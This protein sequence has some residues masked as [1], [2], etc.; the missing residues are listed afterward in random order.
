MIE[1]HIVILSFQKSDN[2]LSLGLLAGIYK[3]KNKP[4][5]KH[6]NLVIMTCVFGE[7]AEW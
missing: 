4:F 6:L 3:L 5:T 1:V 7:L 2:A